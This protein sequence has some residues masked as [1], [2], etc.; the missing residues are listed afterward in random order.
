M[1]RVGIKHQDETLRDDRPIH[2]SC[3][4]PLINASVAILLFFTENRILSNRST[5][6]DPEETPTP[7]EQSA[8]EPSRQEDLV[9][10]FVEHWGVMARS[11][12]INATMGE[13]FALLY[14]TGEN[15]TAEDLRERLQVSRGNVSMNL[16]ELMTWGIVHK[17]HRQGERREYY[18]AELDV[19]TLFKRI[20]Q[21][22]KRRELDPT[23]LVL[24]RSVAIVGEDP[25]HQSMRGRIEDLQQFFALINTLAKRILTLEPDD[26][27]DLRKLLDALGP[28]D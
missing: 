9:R 19:W 4:E 20:F 12:G 2:P 7:P 6:H 26:L 18:R 3:E 11:W 14:I 23:L 5:S 25:A 21:E 28:A 8:S 16:R 17:V 13:L 24:E 27:D 22:R 15:W 1:D 10:Q